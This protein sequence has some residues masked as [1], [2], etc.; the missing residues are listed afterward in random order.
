[1]MSSQPLFI[2][3]YFDE[4]EADLWIALQQIEPE[5][6]T[7]F[8]KETLKQ[9]LIETDREVIVRYPIHKAAEDVL[10]IS[11]DGHQDEETHAE[12]LEKEVENGVERP[13][14]FTLEDLFIQTD[15]PHSD[16]KP[17]N[18]I[19]REEVTSISGYEYMMKHIIGTEEDETVLKILRGK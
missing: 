6:R 9:V 10:E 4:S 17:D 2:P 3:L 19:T 16:E 13:G 11:D 18:M 1:M 7:S 12:E 5:K 15:H 8:I 14:P